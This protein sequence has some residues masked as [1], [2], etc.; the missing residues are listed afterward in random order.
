MYSRSFYPLSLERGDYRCR[1]VLFFPHF[2]GGYPF[3][4]VKKGKPR[5]N[6]SHFGSC[7]IPGH[8]SKH[9][10]GLDFFPRKE[11]KRISRVLRQFGAPEIA[12]HLSTEEAED[13]HK[14]QAGVLGERGWLGWVVLFFVEL[15]FSFFGLGG[16]VGRWVG[17]WYVE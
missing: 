11:A 3:R 6:P 15:F 5:G 17:G 13:L 12:S 9:G 10:N 8:I 2:L 7:D 16:W 1:N 4:L 14:M